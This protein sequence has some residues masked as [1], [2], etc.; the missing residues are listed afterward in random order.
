MSVWYSVAGRDCSQRVEVKDV[1][2]GE[3]PDVVAKACA[4]H[5]YRRNGWPPFITTMTFTIHATAKGRAKHRYA[6]EL[7]MT[8]TFTA[9]AL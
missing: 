4:M 6:I 3:H 1:E 2:I 8:P 7:E 9:T 5:E